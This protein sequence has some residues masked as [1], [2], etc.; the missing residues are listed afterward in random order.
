MHLLVRDSRTLDEQDVAEDLGL[1]PA[2]LVVLSFTESDLLGLLH[3]QARLKV[4]PRGEG[5]TL[6]FL[7]VTSLARLRHPM[8]VD[9]Y[10]ETTLAQAR[11]VVVRLLGGLDYWRYGA[12]ELAA[13]CRAHHIPLALL[14][15]EARPQPGAGAPLSDD[16]RLAELSTV[17]GE[18]RR[19]L[20]GFFQYGG[21]HNMDHALR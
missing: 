2:E 7:Q 5:E 3:A 1:P 21:A 12:E 11:C 15:G 13:W 4:G 16:S 20:N 10:L 18:I 17:S 19:R 6:P 8:S 9:L 14:P